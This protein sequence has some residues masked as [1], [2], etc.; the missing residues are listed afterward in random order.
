MG[1][2]RS[3]STLRALGAVRPVRV[4]GVCEVSRGSDS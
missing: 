4:Y 1:T 2:V 3:F